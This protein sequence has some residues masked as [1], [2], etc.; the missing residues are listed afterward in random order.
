MIPNH[1]LS[2]MAYACEHVFLILCSKSERSI[3]HTSL[4]PVL[5]AS[6]FSDVFVSFFIS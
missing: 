2:D 3:N 4:T 1:L 6:H 5:F